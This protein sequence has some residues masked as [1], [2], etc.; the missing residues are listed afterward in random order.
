MHLAALKIYP[1]LQWRLCRN[2]KKWPFRKG[3]RRS[4]GRDLERQPLNVLTKSRQSYENIR[5]QINAR[6]IYLKDPHSKTLE[7]DCLSPLKFN[8][9][10]APSGG[11]ER[12]EGGLEKQEL[13]DKGEHDENKDSFFSDIFDRWALFGDAWKMPWRDGG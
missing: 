8:Y 12:G 7:P 9:D 4:G 3:E 11:R 1:S 5:F 2:K 6:F 13:E 10:K